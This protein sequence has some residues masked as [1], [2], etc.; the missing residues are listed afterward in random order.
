MSLPIP[1]SELSTTA[2]KE[3][4]TGPT[5]ATSQRHIWE[6][7]ARATQAICVAGEPILPK[8]AFSGELM[9]DS[10][11]KTE[12]LKTA[13]MLRAF[14]ISL[15]GSVDKSNDLLQETLMKA[16]AHRDSFQ[17]GTNLKAW[18]YT[19]LRN[20]FYSSLRKH[21][22]EVED[23]DGKHAATVGTLPSQESWLDLQDMIRALQ[24]LPP[25]QRE[26][27]LLVT[28]SDLSYEEAAEI[29]KVAVGTIKSRVNRARNRLIELLDARDPHQFAPPQS[30]QAALVL[31]E[32]K[33]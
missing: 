16:W 14:A 21:R 30:I 1:D 10:L 12:L 4:L 22:L 31:R 13:P 33:G 23:A 7:K 6:V 9:D 8:T 3:N 18:L 15:A 24:H 32:A 5:A 20:E 25:D 11:F 28:A 26:A 17:M 2:G 19:I 27:L 29:C